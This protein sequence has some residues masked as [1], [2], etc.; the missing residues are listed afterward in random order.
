V[1]RVEHQRA[2]ARGDRAAQCVDVEREA[3]AVRD[4]WHDDPFAAGYR[5]HRGIGVVERL[6][7][8]D[9]G[10]GLDQSENR[11]RDRLGGSYRDQYLGRRVVVDAVLPLPL[12]RDRFPQRRDTDAR[13]VLVEA[14]G[15]G[16][17]GGLEHR[18]RAVL[19]GEPLA[20]V[21]RADPRG[22]R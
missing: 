1:R 5:H 4:Q 16:V 14:L 11:G 18:R 21:H 3:A 10:A 13:R 6:D 8:D 7:Q 20:E 19:V 17:L 22:Q 2:G 12:S 9:L 15:D